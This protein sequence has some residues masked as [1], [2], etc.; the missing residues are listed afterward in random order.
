MTRRFLVIDGD[1]VLYKAAFGSQFTQYYVKLTEDN[2]QGPFNSREDAYEWIGNDDAGV[3][4][5]TEIVPHPEY[6]AVSRLKETVN[7]ILTYSEATDSRIYLTGKGNFR[8][9]LAT[10]LPYKGN[11]DDA[12]KPIHYSFL[13]HLLLTN[14]DARE[15]VGIE[16]DDAMS[17]ASW[18]SVKNPTSWEIC[19][20][21]Q[22]KD[23]NMVPGSHYNPR[24]REVYH[25]TAQEARMNFYSQLLT[26][27]STDNIQ[28][29]YR[30]GKKTAEKLLKPHVNK[31]NSELLRMILQEY[32]RDDEKWFTDG[33]V[34]GVDRMTEVARLLWML[35]SEGQLWSPDVD[36]Y[37]GL[38]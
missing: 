16:A 4:I 1:E 5:I 22:D 37:E 18:N 19:I 35:Q 23:L 6:V 9:D 25:L 15:V 28:G 2:I 12:V 33:R 30:I 3:E 10:I 38:Y 13:R 31:T 7:S 17:I 24:T 32:A 8:F 14:Y 26:G 36:Y 34:K 29:L 21:S 27:D 20:A 11:R